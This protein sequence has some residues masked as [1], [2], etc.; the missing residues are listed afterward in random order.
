MTDTIT[1]TTDLDAKRDEKAK[2]GTKPTGA[3]LVRKGKEAVAAN[4]DKR[5]GPKKSTAKKTNKAAA[6]KQ[7]AEPEVAKI[8]PTFLDVTEEELKAMGLDPKIF[9]EDRL[10]LD[11]KNT[12]FEQWAKTMA[13]LVHLRV[14]HKW[15]LGDAFRLGAEHWGNDAWGI[16]E[17]DRFDETTIGNY[18]WVAEKFLPEERDHDLSWSHHREASAAHLSPRQRIAC[19]KWCHKNPQ[20]NG[21]PASTRLLS[22]HVATLKPDAGKPPPTEK[23]IDHTY[24]VSF[25]LKVAEEEQGD[26]ILARL[27]ETARQLEA[28]YGVELLGFEEAKS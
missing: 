16:F 27:V 19:L 10:V 1:P 2:E 11:I 4:A 14:T 3:D 15:W 22:A 12:S 20:K 13:L 26:A 18:Q 23:K 25:R 9:G 24:R 7:A 17:S 21:K 28:E 6:K 8:D 5:P